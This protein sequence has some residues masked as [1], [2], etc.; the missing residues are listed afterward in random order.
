MT[1][2]A[3]RILI[4]E[5]NRDIAENIG[6]YFDARGHLTDFAMDGITGL[7]LALTE[8][9]DVIILDLMLPGMD[10]LT[11]CAKLRQEGGKATPV[12]MLTARDT[13]DDKLA[14]FDTGADDYLVKPFALEELA[15][16][17]MAL[18]R[19]SSKP[20]AALLRVGDL[21]LNTATLKVHRKGREI[22]LN[23]TCLTILK[24]LMEASPH[25][26][27]RRELEHALWGDTPPGSDALRSHLYTL[28]TKIDKPFN[29]PLLHTLHGI[30]YRVEATS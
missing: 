13:L 10:G 20:A 21:T 8:A 30:G 28:R 5:D 27:T 26:V 11:L 14:G 3:L 12:L 1:H 25:V 23:H 18:S 6:D 19:R 17:V 7:H 29:D 4:I 22:E 16:R 9:Y 24:R 2:N 15:A